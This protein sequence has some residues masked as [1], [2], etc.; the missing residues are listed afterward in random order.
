VGHS[1]GYPVSN[2]V[3]K[4]SLV[5][6]LL[7]ILEPLCGMILIATMSRVM[8]PQTLGAYSFV[9]TFTSLFG[10]VSQMGLDSLIVRE[11]AKRKQAVNEY[12]LGGNLIGICSSAILIAIMNLTKGYFRL[13]VDLDNVLLLM[14]LVLIPSFICSSFDSIFMAFEKMHLIL[15]YRSISKVISISVSLIAIYSGYGLFHLTIILLFTAVLSAFMC[16]YLFKKHISRFRFHLNMKV[17]WFLLKKSPVFLMIT[18]VSILSARIDVL[19]LTRL[20]TLSQVAFYTAAYRLFEMNMVLPLAYIKSNYPQLSQLFHKDHIKFN[21]F[22]KQITRRVSLFVISVTVV[23]IVVAH[24]IV[25]LIYGV[26]FA[27]SGNILII[28]ML[29]LVPWGWGRVFANTLVASNNQRFDLAG[30]VIATIANISL[31]LFLIPRYGMIGAAFANTFSL[32]LFFC[33]EYYFLHLNRIGVTTSVD[34]RRTLLPGL[35]LCLM[36]YMAKWSRPILY[37][38]ILICFVLV[39]YFIKRQGSLREVLRTPFRLIKQII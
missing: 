17:T 11:V 6:I 28:L 8:G 27:D 20:A 34:I 39:A 7:R 31:N 22:C 19:I 16:V 10:A 35:L 4:N 32:S 23:A 5:L 14:S 24:F 12:L 9:V 2:L 13:T 3:I 38:E 15:Y 29:G 33:T 21:Y 26:K 25:T 37:I 1:K 18:L 30:G 36:S